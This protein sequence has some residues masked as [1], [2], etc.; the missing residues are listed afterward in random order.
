MT[1][2]AIL[3]AA[4]VGAEV[5]RAQNPA[6]PYLPEEIAR[7]A[8]D[9]WRAGAA[10]IHLHARWPDGRPSQEAAHFTEIVERIRA[11]GCDAVL[12]CSTG[13][14]VGMSIDERLGSLVLGA[15]MGTLNLGTMNFGDEVFVNARPDIVR[16]ASALRARGLVPECEVYDAGM[17]DTL[18]WLL[19]QG[20]L[21]APYHVQFVLGVPGG[22]SASERNLRFLLEG[23]P[24]QVH[25]SA[26]GVGRHQLP[27]AE[28]A[29]RLGGHAR[30]GLEDNLFVA[31]GVLAR[32]SHE[33]VELAVAAARRADRHPAS[34]AEAR[35]ILGIATA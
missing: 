6:V 20:H 33:L 12:Q 23:L 13:G 28:L 26:A 18:R 11:A 15:E 10:C 19:A 27:L 35:R 29:L 4:V 17:L 2:P 5:T 16:V 1:T 21:A 30:V 7:A 8:V 32:G 3:T 22:L 24:E 14:A 31:K 9:A 25:W 34:P